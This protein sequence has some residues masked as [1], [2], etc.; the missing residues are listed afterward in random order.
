MQTRQ[1]IVWKVRTVK[2]YPEARNHLLVGRVLERDAACVS[3]LCRTFHFGRLVR[4][5]RDIT[6]GPLGR[7]IIPWGRIEV[8][9]ELPGG[10]DFEQA[11][12]RLD[13]AGSLVLSDG[14]GTC[15]LVSAKDRA[16]ATLEGPDT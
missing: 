13:K 2:T 16:E 4:R 11:V 1:H 3:L 14:A 12:V 15:V 5:V 7:R 6:V 10:L 9:N 8:I